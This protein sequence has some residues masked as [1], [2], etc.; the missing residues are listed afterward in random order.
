MLSAFDIFKIGA[1]PSRSHTVDPATV[2]PWLADIRR[3]K[4][5][6][7]P[8]HHSIAFRRER[9]IIFGRPRMRAAISC[10]FGDGTFTCQGE[11]DGLANGRSP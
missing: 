8:A 1:G 7:L 2:E 11:P 6:P 10:F 9:G 4:T 3:T 5:L